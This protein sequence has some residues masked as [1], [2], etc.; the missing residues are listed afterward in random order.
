MIPPLP[1]PP[2]E[3]QQWLARFSDEL[4]RFALGRVLKSAAARP[5]IQQL[6]D[7]WERK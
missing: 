5:R 2:P 7:V 1:P 3:P 6:L 4:Y